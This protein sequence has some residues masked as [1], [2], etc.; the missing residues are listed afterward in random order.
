[1]RIEAIPRLFKHIKQASYA[2]TAQMLGIEKKEVEG[3]IIEA[4][5]LGIMKAKLDEYQ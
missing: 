1:V 5:R 4:I 2:Q 3:Y